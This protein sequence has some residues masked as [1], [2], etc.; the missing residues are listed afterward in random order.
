MKNILKKIFSK[1]FRNASRNKRVIFSNSRDYWEE[2]YQK[3][4]N[5]GPGSYDNLAEFKGEIINQFVERNKVNSVIEFGCGDGNQLKFFKFN[6]YIGFDI[7][8]KSIQLCRKIYRRDNSKK[9]VL[10]DDFNQEK[11]DLTLSL[12]VIYHLI[13]DDTFEDYMKKLFE[14]SKKYVIIYSSNS[15]KVDGAEDVKH[16]K[17]REFTIWVESNIE[18]F[19]LKEIIPNKFPFR[20]SDKNTSFADFY[21]FEKMDF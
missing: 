10:L 11:A 21:I 8:E 4:G 18:G 3:G 2:R 6:S 15:I 1:I 14:S 20:I 17:H 16:I 7:S 13:E 19:L 5:S 12:D 9:F